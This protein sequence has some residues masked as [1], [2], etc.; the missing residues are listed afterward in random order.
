MI[1]EE[2]PKTIEAFRF[3]QVE[4]ERIAVLDVF[5]RPA[6][7][8]QAFASGRLLTFN[9]CLNLFNDK[10]ECI[11][12]I[13]TGGWVLNSYDHGIQL[14]GNDEFERRYKKVT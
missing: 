2:K 13:G 7:L 12:M 10:G 9:Q 8:D 11:S 14:M 5:E 4:G 6:W 1:Y 3:I